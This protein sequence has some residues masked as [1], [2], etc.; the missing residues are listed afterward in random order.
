MSDSKL[1]SKNFVLITVANLFMAIAFYFM[2]PVMSVYMADTF[3]STEQ[4][5]GIAMFAFTIAAIVVRPFAGYLLDGLNR[6]TVYI[7][8]FI[9]FIVSFLGYPLVGTIGLLVALRFFHGMTWGSINT[10]AYTL[11]IDFIPAERRG[12]GLGIFG[13]SMNVAMAISPIIALNIAKATGYM[14]VF[15]TAVAV[16]SVGFILITFL[17]VTKQ[18]GVL[19]R[20]SVS[21]LLERKALPIALN[22][23]ITQIPYGGIIAFIAL[24]SRSIGDA[25]FGIFFIL[26]AVGFVSTR[27]ICGWLYDKFGP[28][29][30]ITGGI[31]AIFVGLIVLGYF[32]TAFGFYSAAVVLGA[33]FGVLSPTFQAMANKYIAPQRR[34]AANS[35]YLACFDSGMA[36]GM[37]LFG[38][39]IRLV[40][41]KGTFFVAAGVEVLAMTF[42]FTVTLPYFRKL[43]S[44]NSRQATV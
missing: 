29:N 32:A 10:S 38:V 37:A 36:L 27:V 34:G 22:A 1:T 4:Q 40:G 13:M 5:V 15:Y 42:F 11:V 18:N 44:E 3:G 20:L 9:L 41:Y 26:M 14:W 2:T 7:V 33:G 21:N 30:V 23:T 24:Y 8:S 31:S 16:C 43:G 12:L 25:N 6:H 35:T 28:R 19:Q 39:L 17:S